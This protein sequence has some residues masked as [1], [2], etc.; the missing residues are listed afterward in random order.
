MK[1]T[2]DIFVKEEPELDSWQDIIRKEHCKGCHGKYK[3]A[4][5]SPEKAWDED[6]WREPQEVVRTS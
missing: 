3:K 1:N 5:K 2:E 4:Q 6:F